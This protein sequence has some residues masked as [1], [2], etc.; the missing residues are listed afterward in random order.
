MPDDNCGAPTPNGPCGNPPTEDNGRCWIPSHSNPDAE[1]PNGR[2]NRLDDERRQQI[3]HTAVSAGLSVKDQAA[4]A[5]VHPDTLRR[6][7]CCVKTPR[8]PTLETDDP[9]N[10]CEGYVQAHARG[11]LE[12]LQECRPEFRAAATFGY[13]DESDVNVNMDADHEHNFG[14]DATAEFITFG[15]EDNGDE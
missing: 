2:P 5:Q 11:A 9:C 15:G 7:L 4:L 14:D 10:F 1:N 13:T 12:V 6:S 3:I 8:E